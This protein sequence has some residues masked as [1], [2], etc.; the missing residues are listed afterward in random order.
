MKVAGLA[1]VLFHVGCCCL[2]TGLTALGVLSIC[3]P[4]VAADLFGL[5]VPA[6]SAAAAS[7]V[8]VAGL[9]DIGLA[10]GVFAVYR[11]EPRGMRYVGPTILAIPIGDAYLTLANGGTVQGALTHL[12]GTIAVAILCGCAWLNEELDRNDRKTR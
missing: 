2:A 6:G 10:L 3:A 8:Q 4:T 11:Y 5:P 12:G 9:R 7:W 1:R